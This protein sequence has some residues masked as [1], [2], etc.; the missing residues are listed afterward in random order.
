MI[1]ADKYTAESCISSDA[2]RLCRGEVP[3][4]MML[5][6][7]IN[8]G[9]DP[10]LEF[11]SRQYLDFY[12]GQGGS[13]IKFL[14][15][16]PGTGKTQFARLFA[17]EALARGYKVVS[18]SAKETWLHDFRELYLEVLRQCDLEA[19]LRGCADSMIAEMGYDA[20]EIPPGQTLMD[21]LA[22]QGL[23]DALT[24]NEIRTALRQHFTRNP[25]LDNTFATCCSLLTGSLLGH[26]VLEASSREMLMAFMHG[27]KSVKL[28]QMRAIGL[29]PSRVT[30]HN[31]R[32]LLR[33]LA[34]IVRF[35]GWSGIV[36]IID[37]MEILAQP[38]TEGMIRYTKTKRD[39]AYE[40]IRQLIDDIDSMR[41]IMFMMAFDRELMDNESYGLK[42]YQA[43]W[44]R[45]Q[46]EVVSSRF[47]QFADIIDLDRLSD[48]VMTAEA[49]V[50]MS[51]KI[52]AVLS[53]AGIE[54]LP[55]D[56]AFAEELTERSEYGSLGLPYLLIRSMSEERR[57][58]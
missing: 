12:I 38:K 4:D 24:R 44:F 30:K 19:V 34:E 57:A 17:D 37:D 53:E 33:S 40:N 9:T 42:S 23:A 7:R 52:S 50:E 15:G 5:V 28:S 58:D 54:A 32:H 27:D 41:Y 29:S 25:L 51:E 3:M 20:S 56:P 31:A 26:P 8:H 22:G 18:L 35:A 45:I 6:R 46:S 43:L 13:K 21:H 49:I 47:N 39:D 10:L 48:Q 55:V 36:V 2:E 14:T 1:G 16:R 11:M